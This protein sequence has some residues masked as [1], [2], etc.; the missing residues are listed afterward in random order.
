MDMLRS[1]PVAL[2]AGRLHES[3]GLF[4]LVRAWAR[5][6]AQLPNARLW[7]AGEGPARDAL[8]GEIAELGL[9][10]RV[11][12]CG[13]FDSVDDLLA[14]ANLFVLP[15]WEEG[16][17]LALLEAMAAGKPIVA[18]DIPANRTLLDDG[19][20]G[21]LVPVREPAPLAEALIRLLTQP[22]LA[23]RLALAARNRVIAEFN[24]TQRAAEHL[25][26]FERLVARRPASAAQRI[27]AEPS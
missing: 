6:T 22:E 20:H 3:K 25:E 4:E 10:G 26:L 16:M 23:A 5:V 17:S 9:D 8:L 21:L 19:V 12:L 7:F 18:S 13:A 1:A 24:L 14:A 15:S 11:V 2:Y 27:L